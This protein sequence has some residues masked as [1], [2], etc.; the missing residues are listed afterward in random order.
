MSIL[1]LN[2]AGC[3]TCKKAK[4]FLIEK[5]I[6]FIDRP[7]VEENPSESEL[8]SW[9]ERSKLPIKKFFNTSGLVYKELNLKEKLPQMSEEEQVKLLSSNGKLIKRPLLITDTEVLVGFKPE[10][11]EK[12]K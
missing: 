3:S 2:Y 7:I 4:K 11:W 5:D 9:I 10:E 1:F 6:K 8:Q 12:I